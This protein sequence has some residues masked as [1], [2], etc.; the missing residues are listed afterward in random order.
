MMP[1]SR[2]DYRQWAR[3]LLV[4]NS[5]CWFHIFFGWTRHAGKGRHLHYTALKPNDHGASRGLMENRFMHLFMS[6]DIYKH[7]QHQTLGIPVRRLSNVCSVR[8]LSELRA[9]QLRV[10]RTLEN[11]VHIRLGTLEEG[12]SDRPCLGV[13]V[14]R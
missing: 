3:K 14:V 4:G 13:I 11:T 7:R 5:S 1:P 6:Y 9:H 2:H 10:Q 12:H 8:F